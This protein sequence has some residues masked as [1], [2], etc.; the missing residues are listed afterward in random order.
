[1]LIERRYRLISRKIVWSIKRIISIKL[2]EAPVKRV[3]SCLR[4]DVNQSGGFPSKFW[5]YIDF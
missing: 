4:G 5:G 3:R 2:K 1:M